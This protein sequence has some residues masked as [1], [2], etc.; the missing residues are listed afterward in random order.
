[1][2]RGAPLRE[3]T[4]TV[5]SK[6]KPPRDPSDAIRLLRRQQAIWPKVRSARLAGGAVTF[7]G[8]LLVLVALVHA[9]YSSR[10][11]GMPFPFLTFVA[12]PCF[13]CLCWGGVVVSRTIG[14]WHGDATRDA[15]V[16]LY[17]RLDREGASE[18]TTGG[19]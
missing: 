18:R 1:M 8:S 2:T 11:Q 7:S 9:E 5:D 14:A 6:G 10:L 13:L 17:D 19:P 12:V 15:V 3:R 16:E 4:L